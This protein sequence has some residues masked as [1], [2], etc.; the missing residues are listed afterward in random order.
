M[1]NLTAYC[2]LDC[3]KCE[4]YIATQADDEAAKEKIAERWRVEFHSP[5]ITAAHATCDGCTTL[6][7]RAGGYCGQCPLR[8]CASTRAVPTCAHCDDYESCEHLRGF[9]GMAPSMK[10]V[11]DGI[12]AASGKT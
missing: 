12:R 8:A 6:G 4:A 3:S 11:L 2:G 5:E 10:D 7:G 1:A 9:F